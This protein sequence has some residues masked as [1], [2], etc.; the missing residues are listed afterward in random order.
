MPVTR[1]ENIDSDITIGEWLAVEPIEVLLQKFM[2]NFGS[3]E[4]IQ[5]MH[6]EKF[7]G[8]AAV[9]LLCATMLPDMN[10]KKDELGK[11]FLVTKEGEPLEN[12]PFVS[13]THSK[14]MAAVI[15]NQKQ[16]TG[17]DLELKDPRVLRIKNKFCN[18]TDLSN[19]HHHTDL[20][21]LLLII[22]G[23]KESMYKWYGKKE[24][25]FK[26]HMRVFPFALRKSGTFRC[27]LNLPGTHRVFDAAY[28][29]DQQKVLVYLL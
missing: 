5:N 29:M 22:W 21:E 18:E 15:V 16:H 10:F 6:P 12:G 24:V 14:N 13:W 27:E 26:K 28:E 20:T 2:E 3:S 9:R 19:S 17:I 4:D 23:A 1:I 11:P 7:R 8:Y 25:D